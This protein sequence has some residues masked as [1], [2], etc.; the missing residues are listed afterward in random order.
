MVAD[1]SPVADAEIEIPVV[2]PVVD[3]SEPE[4]SCWQKALRKYGREILG[5]PLRAWDT[6][7]LLLLVVVADIGL[8]LAPGGAGAGFVLVCAAAGLLALRWKNARAAIVPGLV[9]LAVALIGV[10]RIW[11][12]LPFVGFFALLVMAVKLYS[13]ENRILEAVWGGGVSL[14]WG[15]VRLLGHVVAVYVRLYG[16]DLDETKGRKGRIP[17]RAVLIPIATCIVFIMIFSASNPVISQVLNKAF[18]QIAAWCEVLTKHLSFL[19]FISWGFWLLLFAALMRPLKNSVMNKIMLKLDGASRPTPS[20]GDNEANYITALVTLLSVNLLFMAYNAMDSVYLYFKATLPKGVTWTDYTHAGCGWLTFGLVV[21]TAVI[22]YIFAGGLNFH[23]KSSRLK[24]LVDIWALQNLVLAIGSI[25]RLLMYI[26][27]SGL[28][29]LR[30]TGIYGSILVAVGLI[31]M[32]VKVHRK[33][34]FVWILHKDV[35]AFAVALIVLALTPNDYICVKYNVARVLEGKKKALRPIVLKNLSSEAI[36]VLIPL[37]DYEREDGNLIKRNLVRKEIASIIGMH[38]DKLDRDKDKPWTQWQGS[39]AWAL[40]E[41]EADRDRVN[42]I[43]P[44]AQREVSRRM[45]FN[46]AD[47]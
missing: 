32:V 2:K 43:A 24:L 3:K 17:L 6:A 1:K 11:W 29:H 14:F 39:H 4:L 15:P 44:P 33:H 35:L 46:N 8:Y 34:G 20:I 13:P 21:S 23:K 25:R 12:L 37:L 18:D 28:T 5:M 38:L 41:L 7:L 42:Q 27:Y 9:V 31:I 16:G 26:D 30:I 19:R 22:G 10:W 40:K 45:L 36:P 47:V